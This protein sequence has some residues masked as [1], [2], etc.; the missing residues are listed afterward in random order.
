MRNVFGR[1]LLLAAFWTQIASPVL[2]DEIFSAV[3]PN[4][5]AV[6]R[7]TAATA[8]ASILN[9]SGRALANCGIRPS[10][11]FPGTFT[12]RP[13]DPATNAPIGS[14][15]QKIA[16]A[17]DQTGT[18]VFSMLANQALNAQE[19]GLIFQCD[20]VAPALIASGVNTITLT[21]SDFGPPDII[22]IADTL[23]HDGIVHIAADATSSIFVAA[24]VNIGKVKDIVVTP[25][26]NGSTAPVTLTICET[27][28]AGQC[29]A[30]PS[31]SVTTTFTPNVA[32]FYTITVTR[33]TTA[34]AVYFDPRNNRAYLNFEENGFLRANSSVAILSE[35]AGP[36]PV[37]DSNE[38]DS[39]AA[40]S[41]RNINPFGFSPTA[42]SLIVEAQGVGLS[43][44]ANSFAVQLNGNA[45]AGATIAS[46]AITIPSPLVSGA[47]V[48]AVT[49]TDNTGA[50]LAGNFTV[51]AG[52]S[53]LSIT[54]K[55]AAGAVVAGARVQLRLNDDPRILVEAT[56]N[57]SGIATVP[58]VPA[59][60]IAILAFDSAL[61][62]SASTVIAGTAGST[63]LTLAPVGSPSA[64]NN[65]D[66][67]GGL[68][69]WVTTGSTT[70][71]PH[72]EGSSSATGPADF[73]AAATDNDL[74]ISTNNVMTSQSATYTFKAPAGSSKFSVRFMFSTTEFPGGYCGTQYNDSFGVTVKVVNSDGSPG[75]IQTYENSMNGLGCS[76]F[77]AQG[78][79]KWLTVQ[80]AVKPGA[81]IEIS[82]HVQ[83]VGDGA[84]Q[85]F[86]I[87]DGIQK[88]AITL[89]KAVFKDLTNLVLS[90]WFSLA[91]TVLAGVNSI[92]VNGTIVLTGDPGAQ[93]SDV[94]L[95]I[96]QGSTK[97]EGVL[98]NAAKAKLLQPIPA[99]GSLSYTAT[100]NA[101]PLFILPVI[102]ATQFDLCSTCKVTVEAVLRIAN[103]PKEQTSNTKSYQVL[104]RTDSP[105]IGRFGQRDVPL[106]GDD[107]ANKSMLDWLAKFSSGGY[108]FNDISKMHGGVFPQHQ[109]HRNGLH[110][111]MRFAT[112]TLTAS[113]TTADAQELLNLLA[114]ANLGPSIIQ[115]YVTYPLLAGKTTCAPASNID[116][117][118]DF[119]KTISSAGKLTK[120]RCVNGHKDHIHVVVKQ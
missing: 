64:G 80:V 50:Q 107:W 105:G 111:D 35:G 29:L 1:I 31:A 37:T 119:Y 22:P 45:V 67:S 93:A 52:N 65:L 46:D 92:R 11:V 106:G 16:I 25:S 28:S 36:N 81:T 91:P 21:V 96:S 84:F 5:R 51:W 76:A 33:P 120:I 59:V 2:A 98:G 74:K 73:A 10:G 18:F 95:R 97:I 24:A 15:N 99:T 44:D 47:N 7:G 109:T 116:T 82:G 88:P 110:I 8:F 20:G 17:K 72:A 83:N 71:V 43:T 68:T 23:T 26:L 94:V 77:D 62:A 75:D 34:D 104:T 41:L 30:P 55:T 86:L 12:F 63:T 49:A 89:S 112:M 103:D 87:I 61:T 60:P 108:T 102:T 9:A 6:A 57:A 32:K 54:V 13:T 27:N 115:I 53:T 3:L 78:N 113:K 101:E 38:G 117:T 19:F 40:L 42:T 90:D 118:S 66:I 85:S 39:E 56:T 4:A 79:T 48:I 58:N 114:D 70:V 69:G 14:D 100:T